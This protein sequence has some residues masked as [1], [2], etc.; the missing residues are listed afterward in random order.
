MRLVRDNTG[1]CAS[2]QLQTFKEAATQRSLELAMR[3]SG[4]HGAQINMPQKKLVGTDNAM[5]RSSAGCLGRQAMKSV[6]GR[7]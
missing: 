5:Q 4:P 6:T 7:C 3:G 2:K 1:Q